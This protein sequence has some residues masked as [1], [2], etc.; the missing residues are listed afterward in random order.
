ML[1]HFIEESVLKLRI[2][3]RQGS[4][5]DE[6]SLKNFHRVTMGYFKDPKPEDE[7]ND[8]ILMDDD[9]L[10]SLD[11]SI[12]AENT[13]ILSPENKD[14]E[15]TY[16]STR[17]ERNVFY[18]SLKA[19]DAFFKVYRSQK[20]KRLILLKKNG[21]F[22]DIIRENISQTNKIPNLGKIISTITDK[23]KLC[24]SCHTETSSSFCQNI[25]CESIRSVAYVYEVSGGIRLNYVTPHYARFSSPYSS[26]SLLSNSDKEISLSL[27]SDNFKKI[28]TDTINSN[29][30]SLSFSSNRIV[31]KD[32]RKMAILSSDQQDIV[33][34][35]INFWECYKSESKFYGIIQHSEEIK[36]PKLTEEVRH[37]MEEKRNFNIESNEGYYKNKV[38]YVVADYYGQIEKVGA[39]ELDTSVPKK[40]LLKTG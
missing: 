28:V 33:G 18:K 39:G 38:M 12:L 34:E 1:N 35:K 24:L 10:S 25:D 19:F 13:N 31:I 3:L 36:T 17:D 26:L 8:F 14:I 2:I 11:R 27:F 16:F 37:K 23:T 4:K 6:N 21:F 40:I 30:F 32:N 9:V 29:E 15:E 5:S 20:I 22:N 7:L